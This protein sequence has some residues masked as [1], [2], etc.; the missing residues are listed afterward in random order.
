MYELNYDNNLYTG[1]IDV[2]FIAKYPYNGTMNKLLIQLEYF[3][4]KPMW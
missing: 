4:T 2:K 1:K 3:A